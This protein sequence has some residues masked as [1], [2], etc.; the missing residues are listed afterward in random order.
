[1]NQAVT[2]IVLAAGQSKRMRSAIAK[3]LHPLCGQPMIQWVL[4]ATKN[5]IAQPPIVVVGT[6]KELIKKTLAKDCRFKEQ[7]LQLGS[8]H[9]A[10]MAYDL[11]C[12]EQGNVFILA[13]DMPLIQ[14]ETLEQL[15]EACP[16]GGVSCLKE[17]ASVCCIDIAAFGA[18]M[19][20]ILEEAGECS[21]ARLVAWLEQSGYACARIPS[22]EHLSVNDRAQ[23]ARCTAILRARI[24][25]AHMKNGVTLMDPASTYIDGAVKIGYDTTIYPGVVLEGNTIVEEGA[26]LYPGCRI[27]DSHI[28]PQCVLQAVVAVDAVVGRNVAIGPYVNLRPGARIADFC[29]IGDFVEVKNSTI[30]EGTKLPHLSYIGDADVGKRVNAGCGT[31]FVN[32]DGYQKHRTSV[33]DGAFLG[34]NT[35]L[36]A[37]VRVGENAYTAAGSVITNNVPDGALAV[38]RAKQVN[39][40]G[41]VDNYREKNQNNALGDTGGGPS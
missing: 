22:N 23:L 34:C 38:A 12:G 11:V 33:G 36:V 30:G 21:L 16:Y 8:A 5:L 37:P 31:V 28:G 40:L 29:K 1:M 14:R 25:D 32:Y 18:G 15:L 24:N 6:Q 41:W 27:K 7:P 35:S 19:Q 26:T 4:G 17:S 39:K 2:A 3:V 20:A 9:A 10:Y 13:G